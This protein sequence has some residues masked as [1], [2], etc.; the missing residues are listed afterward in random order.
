MQDKKGKSMVSGLVA[1]VVGTASLGWMG[2]RQAPK[3]FKLN[4]KAGEDKGTIPI[5]KGL[6]APVK[7]Y[8][9]VVFD[10]AIPVIETAVVS[11]TARLRVNGVK[12]PARFKF[13][14]RAGQAY[15][16]FIQATWF[17]Q[18]FLTVHEQYKDGVSIMDVMGNRTEN[19]PNTNAAANLG[20][21]AESIW[22]PSIFFTDSRVR[23]EAIDADTARLRV[24]YAAPEEGIT[25]TFDPET[26]L[27]DTM[28]ADR[29][30]QP[31]DK[32]RTPWT[33]RA[34]KWETRG[35]M[36][37]PVEADTRWKKERPW[38]VWN[39]QELRYNVD[40]SARFARFGGKVD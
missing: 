22:L 29:Y 12:M 25:I 28:Q 2:L 4:Y 14:Y 13:Y 30:R 32:Q 35:G 7:R 10:S 9:E 24:P 40:V 19:D 1:G 21:W 38:A 27:I 33:N 39:I 36:L 37:I 17:G 3:A 6:P 18:P 8:A 23:W 15:Y 31:N 16:H 26:G 34:L 20:L 11:G 5:P